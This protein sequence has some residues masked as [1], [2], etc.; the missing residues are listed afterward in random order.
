[1][2]NAELLSDR[3]ARASLEKRRHKETERKERIF[4]DKLRT[5]GVDKEAL[6][7]Q[8]K[9]K[10]EQEA[11]AK[12]EQIA[13]DADMCRNSKVARI[14]HNR[15]MKEKRAL[16]K[17]IVTY[18]RQHQQPGE[19]HGYDL[20]GSDRVK[21][22]EQSDAQMMPPGLVG[23]DP[24]SKSRLQRQREQLREWLIQQQTAQA[25]ERHQQKLE[26]Q[27]Y[28]QSKVEMDNRAVQLQ[29]LEMERRKAAAIAT[30]HFNLAM[31]SQRNLIALK[32]CY[33][34]RREEECTDKQDNF[35]GTEWTPSMVAV[36][37]LGPSSDRKAPPESLQQIVQFQ[38]YQIEEKRV[39][40]FWHDRVRLNS[41]RTALLIE[42][43][44]ARL[45][46]QLRRDL[47]SANVQLAETHKQKPELKRGSIDD[48]FF[49]KF[50]TC[51]R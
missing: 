18:R 29:S 16:E 23:E 26:E 9:E 22:T 20:N 49:S 24:E 46:R 43:Q 36:P 45:N 39:K 33:R 8:V 11:A 51:S 38:K 7:M 50:N 34:H 40:Q 28:Y 27:Q 47:D 44:Q 19:R 2:L 25:A 37:G 31:V 30:K 15:Q 41:T 21:T 48:S 6:D 35:Q 5:I 13:Y 32:H 42:R 17:D 12:K 3:L 14:L 10:R 1:M 4:N